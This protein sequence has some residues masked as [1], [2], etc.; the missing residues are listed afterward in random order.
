MFAL[1]KGIILRLFLITIP[2]LLLLVLLLEAFTRLWLTPSDPFW[3]DF[4]PVLGKR[5]LPDQQGEFISGS[6]RACFRINGLGWNSPHEYTEKRKSAGTFRLAVIGDSFVEAFQVDY[7]KSF[8]YLLEKQLRD[9][10]LLNAFPEDLEIYSFG[11]EG[12][13]MAQYINMAGYATGRFQPDLLIINMVH[14]DFLFN[15]QADSRIDDLSLQPAGEGFIE[16]PPRPMKG[17]HAKNLLKRS[18]FVRYLIYNQKIFVRIY[19]LWDFLRSTP[20]Y[21]A[22]TETPKPGKLSDPG[23]KKQV[24]YILERLAG[25]ARNN[26]TEIIIMMDGVRHFIY[27]GKDQQQAGVYRFN[28]LLSEACREQGI[29]LIDLSQSFLKDWSLNQEKF[30]FTDDGHWNERG[31]RVA[32]DAL[33]KYFKDNGL[34]E[35]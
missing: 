25:I 35:A 17:I 33:Y 27:Q 15:L 31:H 13:S 10:P 24:S 2:A 12:A 4:D 30:D 22:N 9:E 14:N 23:L 11:R 8:P 6:I 21:E 29:D 3:H 26:N 28:R 7:D 16:V 1:F 34:I 18:A 5:Y 20:L 32:A 19:Q